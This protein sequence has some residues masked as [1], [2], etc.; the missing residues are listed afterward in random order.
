MLYLLTAIELTP[1][2]SSTVTITRAR[3]HTY[4]I[5]NTQNNTIKLNTQ[6]GRYITIRIHKHNDKNT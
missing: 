6:N 2:G 4:T 3:A 5:H 1:C